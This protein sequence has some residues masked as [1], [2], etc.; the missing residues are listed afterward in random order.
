MGTLLFDPWIGYMYGPQF[1]ILYM[2]LCI[3]IIL[4][5]RNYLPAWISN[6]SAGDSSALPDEVTLPLKPDAYEIAFLRGGS[7]EVVELVAYQLIKRGFLQLKKDTTAERVMINKSKKAPSLVGLSELERRVFGYATNYN[8]YLVNFV[9]T[10]S[11]DLVKEETEKLRVK[12]E[13]Q[14]LIS[15]EK[16]QIRYKK[17]QFGAIIFLVVL[18]FYKLAAALNHKHNNVL[19]LVFIAFVAVRMIAAMKLQVRI[20][21]R[22]KRFLQAA[23][24]AF[25][26]NTSLSRVE[27]PNEY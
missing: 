8:Q 11:V 20:T 7:L 5:L 21:V 12:L 17:Y 14:G 24:M 13:D 15:S 10:V 27:I 9:R 25:P 6:S 1:L 3:L 16:E 26:K 22:G 2:V 19:F 4:V 18:A 23:E